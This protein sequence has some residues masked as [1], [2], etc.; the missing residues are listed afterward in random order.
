MEKV[1]RILI[2]LSLVCICYSQGAAVSPPPL[3]WSTTIG[4]SGE[5]YGMSIQQTKD[6]GYIIAGFTDSYGA[7]L[8]DIYLIKLDGQPTYAN[9]WI[10]Q[11]TSYTKRYFLDR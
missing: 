6:G 2:Y 1:Y 7:G 11:E 9:L 10:D 5:D 3:S 4:S 8:Y